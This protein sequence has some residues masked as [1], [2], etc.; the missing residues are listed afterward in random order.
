MKGFI[1]TS[2]LT[3]ILML[4]I[5]F[6][7]SYVNAV[8]NKMLELI[9]SVSGVPSQENAEA[10]QNLEEYWQSEL[11][12]MK[13]SVNR[14]DID[15]ISNIIDTIKAANECGDS[16]QVAINIELLINAIETITQPIQNKQE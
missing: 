13:L 5:F 6:N 14:R 3:I 10:I 2:I 8:G 1:I 11:I 12:K 9:S 16:S 15:D 4:C 7:W